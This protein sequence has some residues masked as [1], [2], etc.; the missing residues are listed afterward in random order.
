MSLY[1][2]VKRVNKSKKKKNKK[3]RGKGFLPF[4]IFM[5]NKRATQWKK[6]VGKV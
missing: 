5:F 2:R 3:G 6:I 4:L 1:K